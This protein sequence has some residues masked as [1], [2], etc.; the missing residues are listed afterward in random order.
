MKTLQ[1]LQKSE[2]EQCLDFAELLCPVWGISPKRIPKL[3]ERSLELLKSE[4]DA[5]SAVIQAYREFAAKDILSR[6]KS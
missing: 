2:A 6:V 4:E 3:I 5:R 1:E